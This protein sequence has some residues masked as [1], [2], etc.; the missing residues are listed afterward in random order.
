MEWFRGCFVF[1]VV[2]RFVE[3]CDGRV[4]MLCRQCCVSMIS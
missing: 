3:D 1:M 2:F 4:P